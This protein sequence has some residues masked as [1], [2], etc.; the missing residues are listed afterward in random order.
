M[1]QMDAFWTFYGLIGRYRT[2]YSEGMAGLLLNSAVLDQL[3][4]SRLP[5]VV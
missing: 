5:T 3:V 4:T 1:A 2:L